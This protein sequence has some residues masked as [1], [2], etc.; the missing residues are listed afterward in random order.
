MPRTV[1]LQDNGDLGDTFVVGRL[2]ERPRSSGT[3]LFSGFVISAK[4]NLRSGKYL[5]TWPVAGLFRSPRLS[6]G[7]YTYRLAVEERA[8]DPAAPKVQNDPGGT[9]DKGAVSNENF[10]AG[11]R[12]PYVKV[13]LREFRTRQALLTHSRQRGC[14]GETRK[15]SR[16]YLT[17][18]LPEVPGSH[19][20]WLGLETANRLENRLGYSGTPL[21]AARC[22]RRI[23]ELLATACEGFGFLLRF[24][25]P[26]FHVATT[27][28]AEHK[29]PS[30]PGIAKSESEHPRPI[31]RLNTC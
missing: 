13:V 31:G 22:F 17:C 25:F 21:S 6:L 8:Q 12:R 29:G 26:F 5:P 4:T 10:C 20:S 24:Q 14:V 2:V 27:F 3:H 11:T 23:L 15:D 28:P 1:V 7:H 19:N 30:S 9:M 16:T 18:T